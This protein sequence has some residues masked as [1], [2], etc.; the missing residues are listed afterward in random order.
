MVEPE[1]NIIDNIIPVD[2]CYELISKYS[3]LDK[4]DR[5]NKSYWS[6]GIIDHSTTVLVNELNNHE[7]G[8]ILE[9]LHNYLPQ[10]HNCYFNAMFY[11]WSHHSYIPPHNDGHVD[12]AI[13]IH[14]NEDYLTKEGGVFM[15]KLSSK[16]HQ[17]D[18]WTGVEPLFNRTV[19]SAGLVDHW[20]TPV[21]SRR[22]RLSLQLFNL[23]C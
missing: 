13:T 8:R 6:D 9:H 22:D 17:N 14:L 23:K 12:H 15:Y 5:T 4:V 19:H 21:T 2:L 1:V 11:R 7:R 20:V 18:C 3:N 10:I 16:P